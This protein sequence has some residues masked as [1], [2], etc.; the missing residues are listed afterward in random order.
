M[1]SAETNNS[2]TR[3]T[4]NR[5]G[6]TPRDREKFDPDAANAQKV[7]TLRLTGL[8]RRARARGLTLRHSDYGYSLIDGTDR[9]GGR[10]DLTLDDVEAHL[11]TAKT[12]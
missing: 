3:A 9:V 8:R 1:A 4:A 12:A 7:K 5:S 2:R 11:D 6:I 10:G